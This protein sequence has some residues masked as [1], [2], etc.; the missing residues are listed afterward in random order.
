MDDC[1]ICSGTKPLPLSSI[2]K[3][4]RRLSG[5]T[6]EGKYVPGLAS[7]WRSTVRQALLGNTIKLVL[8][9]LRQIRF[10]KI[11]NTLD[12]LSALQLLC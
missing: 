11:N 4:T 12:C 7:A 3:I 10:V 8:H 9:I 5:D 2:D 6:L 1:G